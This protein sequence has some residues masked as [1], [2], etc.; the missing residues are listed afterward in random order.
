M[1]GA[2]PS[3]NLTLADNVSSALLADREQAS[4]NER[5]S[6]DEG[7]DRRKGGPRRGKTGIRD[8]FASRGMD[9]DE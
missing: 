2:L 6:D 5:E 3:G 9:D 1:T 4:D 8:G 7:I